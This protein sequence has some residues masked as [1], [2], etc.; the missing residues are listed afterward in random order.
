[1]VPKTPGS[2]RLQSEGRPV[3]P[4]TTARTLERVWFGVQEVARASAVGAR[5]VLDVQI[6]FR[7]ECDALGIRDVDR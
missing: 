5:I 2:D 6:V 7:I 1:M 3:C 4:M